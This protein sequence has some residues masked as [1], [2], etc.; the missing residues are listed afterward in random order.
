MRAV[1]VDGRDVPASPTLPPE[2]GAVGDSNVQAEGTLPH[3]ATPGSLEGGPVGSS[4]VAQETNELPPVPDELVY[5]LAHQVYLDEDG[6]APGV[7]DGASADDKAFW[8][9][10]S[11]GASVEPEYED[12]DEDEDEDGAEAAEVKRDAGDLD[13]LDDLLGLDD[14]LV[15]EEDNPKAV[16]K[17]DDDDDDY[18]TFLRYQLLSMDGSRSIDGPVSMDAGQGT[19][20]DGSLNANYIS[21]VFNSIDRRGDVTL[22]RGFDAYSASES[23]QFYWPDLAHSHEIEAVMD[24]GEAIMACWQARRGSQVVGHLWAYRARGT[25]W[26]LYPF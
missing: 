1:P 4:V 6:G 3:R 25:R 20:D 26:C 5:I 12:E 24:E 21:A 10:R 23:P 19:N 9:G 22:F 18:T 8:L 16:V 2:G 14:V 17:W 11:K 13:D 7:G 15:G